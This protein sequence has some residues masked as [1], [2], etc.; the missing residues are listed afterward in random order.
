MLPEDKWLAVEA[1]RALAGRGRHPPTKRRPGRRARGNW[2][3]MELTK[4]RRSDLAAPVG[5]RPRMGLDRFV[6]ELV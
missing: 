2:R 4:A 1:L 6:A 3:A 5:S